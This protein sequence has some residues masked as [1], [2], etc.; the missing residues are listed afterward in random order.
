[1]EIALLIVVILGLGLNLWHTV[2]ARDETEKQF[3]QIRV[4][5]IELGKM[6]KKINEKLEI[7]EKELIAKP[8]RQVRDKDFL[9]QFRKEGE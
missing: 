7:V 5:I 8:K 3:E 1:M 2:L 9:D 4:D 6:F